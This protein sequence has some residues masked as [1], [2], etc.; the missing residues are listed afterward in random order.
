MDLS[1]TKIL[2]D[3]IK[4]DLAKTK[5][6]EIE[7]YFS[8]I[9]ENFSPAFTEVQK[10]WNAHKDE[11]AGALEDSKTFLKKYTDIIP[12]IV[13]DFDKYI[14]S[15]DGEPSLFDE[16]EKFTPQGIQNEL[17][18]KKS[19]PEDKYKFFS[20]CESLLNVQKSFSRNA[21]ALKAALIRFA[22]EELTKRKTRKNVQ[23]F[24]DLLTNLRNAL[25][26]DTRDKLI[27]NIRSKFTAALI[28]EFQDT[29]PI[30]FEIFTTLF[31]NDDN[32]LF[33]IG[34]PKQA[35]YGFRGADIFAYLEA[36]KKNEENKRTLGTNFRSQPELI[37]V[38]NKIFEKDRS[39]VFDEIR[40]QK[41]NAPD[42]E[43][44]NTDNLIVDGRPYTPFHIWDFKENEHE[45]NPYFIKIENEETVSVLVAAEIR[46]LLQL[47]LNSHA[48]IGDKPLREKDIAILVKK[49]KQAATVQKA[50]T[51]LGII[52]VIY[53]SGNVFDSPEAI[54]MER[55]LNCIAEPHDDR[56]VKAALATDIMGCSLK[57]IDKLSD[58]DNK[59][60]MWLEKFRKYNKLWHSSGFIKMFKQFL[61]DGLE[62]K[63]DKIMPRLMM[64]EDGDRRNTNLLHLMELLHK[65][66]TEEKLS[67]QGLI[68][69]MQESRDSELEQEEHQLRLESDDEAVKI[70][71]IH[72][73]KGLE[74]P[75]V[76]LPFMWTSSTDAD[77][78]IFH[79]RNNDDNPVLELGSENFDTNKMF[80]QNEK[81][82]EE[83]RLF[84][85]AVT[86]AKNCCYLIR[87]EKRAGKLQQYLFSKEDVAR[88]Q[89]ELKDYIKVYDMPVDTGKEKLP[90]RSTDT[91]VLT[92][93]IFNGN[94]DTKS[95]I[96]SY[97]AM[98]NRYADVNI[99]AEM[100]TLSEQEQEEDESV[101]SQEENKFS[102]F[103][104]AKGQKTGICLHEIL[105]EADYQSEDK[106]EFIN[107]KLSKFRFKTEF[108]PAVCEMI[109]A[110][111]NTKL[112]NGVV[113][114]R[115][116]ENK[117]IHEMEFFFPLK[118][119][120][121]RDLAGIF[122]KAYA[123]DARLCSFYKYLDGLRNDEIEG[124]MN[125]LID[126]FFE[127]DDRYYV[128]DWKSNYLGDNIRAY[129]QDNIVHAMK[130]K[131]YILQ[132]HLYCVAAHKHL[133][134]VKENY[135]YETDFGGVFYLFLR[136]MDITAGA[137][138]GVFYHK[139][140]IEIIEDL[141]SYLTGTTG[142]NNEK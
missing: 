52:S 18:A 116:S 16:L 61:N 87:K 131:L 94:I 121:C 105:E 80:Y 39:F 32:I 29:D 45:K 99:P 101:A 118:T 12:G 73:S 69:W 71:T 33:L 38:V 35:I 25:K 107:K 86:R 28:D 11:I 104:F 85:V 5:K 138:Y 84:Y 1:I 128:A 81:L 129:G 64:Y 70:I 59:Y 3:D 27:S 88:L 17:K 54:E 134:A 31:A 57:D 110:T 50:L 43:D 6:E 4:I 122:E 10:I 58:D 132:Y 90:R 67:P 133:K 62:N 75:V 66:E 76:F 130:E 109:D 82:A 135:N 96:A 72:K 102:R 36:A 95:H 60:D 115:V 22:D 15:N 48:K 41:V 2:P 106:S 113:L 124:F 55:L 100:D 120:K 56:L 7:K 21:K 98:L 20:S 49:N 136:G 97:T 91:S 74:Y 44:R 63:D 111:L 126:I 108:T 103:T 137:D 19:L 119:I 93:N 37:E 9:K 117:R 127:S 26:S 51:E 42:E 65:A 24:N 83:L 47:G 112:N 34:D 68:K 40:Y 139:P 13:H 125:G 23:S 8:C 92:H 141:S 142:V 46:R 78:F 114:S 140:P 53:N 123:E 30:Q 14:N 79:D 77:T 89:F